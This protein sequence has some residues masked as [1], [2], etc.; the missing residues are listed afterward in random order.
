MSLSDDI[1]TYRKMLFVQR[2]R[3]DDE[4]EVQAELMERI[5]AATVVRNSRSI[6]AKENLSQVEA[7]L[8]EDARDDDPKLTAAAAD[9]KIRRD[10]ERIK[11]WRIFQAA[12]AEHEQ[13]QGLQD[14]WRQRGFS[15][16]TLA[17]L[18]TANYYSPTSTTNSS[19]GADVD[20][21]TENLRARMRSAGWT[22]SDRV[23]AVERANEE[24]SE[25]PRRVTR[26]TL[27]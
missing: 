1:N 8:L 5:S 2:H 12:R 9:A 10:P 26:R 22:P 25:T 24:Q 15:I 16:K 18:Y 19:R 23:R 3:L 17:D 4:L 27:T 6:E 21:D 13:W 14:A 11:A 20:R 7:R